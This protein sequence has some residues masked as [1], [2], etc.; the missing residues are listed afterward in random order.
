MPPI[1]NSDN[2]YAATIGSRTND[3]ISTKATPEI[4]KILK[5]KNHQSRVVDNVLDFFRFKETEKINHRNG[6]DPSHTNARAQIQQHKSA[7]VSVK[8]AIQQSSNPANV[9]G[10][11][12]SSD[13][14]SIQNV[15]AKPFKLPATNIVTKRASNS[16]NNQYMN[17][18]QSSHKVTPRVRN[19]KKK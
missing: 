10:K 16:N 7:D 13:F 11:K 8:P 4:S 6:D 3:L 18:Q 1:A 14:A 2:D 5:D 17:I 9:R 19:N 12:L 15:S